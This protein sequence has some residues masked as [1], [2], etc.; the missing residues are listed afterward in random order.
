MKNLVFKS[1]EHIVNISFL[2]KTSEL[3]ALIPNN[4]KYCVVLDKKISNFHENFV[5]ELKSK[6]FQFLLLIAQK[7]KKILILA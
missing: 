7:N 3:S 5:D 6:T 1:E 2:G 4:K